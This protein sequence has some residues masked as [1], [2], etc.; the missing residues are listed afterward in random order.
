MPLPGLSPLPG[1][2]DLERLVQNRLEKVQQGFLALQFLEAADQSP[3]VLEVVKVDPV[4]AKRTLL[5]CAH[6]HTA[7]DQPGAFITRTLE[8]VFNDHYRQAKLV[9]DFVLSLGKHL[10][11]TE[12]EVKKG[13]RLITKNTIAGHTMS[14]STVLCETALT[15]HERDHSA[16]LM[17]A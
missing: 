12:R 1:S 11:K 8:V 7:R 16:R 3:L 10:G 5:F 6:R 15:F 17:S 14:A 4:P 13:R 9:N 2:P